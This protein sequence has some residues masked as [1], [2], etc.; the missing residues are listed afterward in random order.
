MG[1]RSVSRRLVLTAS[2][3][4]LLALSLTGCG[5][6]PSGKSYPV[7]GKVVVDGKPAPAAIVTLHPVSGGAEISK[8]VANTGKDGEFR[9]TSDLG[10]G[11]PAGDYKVTVVWFQP[12]VGRKVSE[13]DDASVRNFLPPQ[14]ANPET[15]PLKTTI[16]PGSNEPL[17]IV[18]KRR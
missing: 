7:A 5:G 12:V 6:T 2:V 18:I 14:Y 11:A 15:T 1:V 3:G 8:P 13:G 4:G 10:E 9:L 16:K 17:E